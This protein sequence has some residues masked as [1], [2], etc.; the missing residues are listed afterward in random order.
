MRP[1]KV[2]LHGAMLLSNAAKFSLLCPNYAP[3]CTI[4]MRYKFNKVLLPESG[5]FL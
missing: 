3:L 5:L 4:I 2:G 1:F